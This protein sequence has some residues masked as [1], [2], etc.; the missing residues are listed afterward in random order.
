LKEKKAVLTTDMS[1][2]NKVKKVWQLDNEIQYVKKTIKTLFKVEE[3][4]M[5]K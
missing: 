2:I 4:Q 1:E 3:K 5:E